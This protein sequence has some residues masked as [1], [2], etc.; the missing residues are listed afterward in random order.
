MP[1][2]DQDRSGQAVKGGIIIAKTKMEGL[3]TAERIPSAYLVSIYDTE[4]KQMLWNRADRNI[5]PSAYEH[6]SPVASPAS[7]LRATTV[8]LVARD[9]RDLGD[10]ADSSSA[11]ADASTA[12]DESSTTTRKRDQA[13]VTRSDADQQ[14][15]QPPSRVRRLFTSAN[16]EPFTGDCPV[17][18]TEYVSTC[19]GSWCAPFA[20]MGPCPWMNPASSAQP[21]IPDAGAKDAE[22][23]RVWNLRRHQHELAASHHRRAR[24]KASRGHWPAWTYFA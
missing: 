2:R 15:E 6:S 9:D 20:A 18:M 10:E 5:E 21:A 12:A 17:C 19:Q 22:A 14:A 11:H 1:H 24:C 13:E 4:R 8:N 16:T 23:Q 7:T 3:I